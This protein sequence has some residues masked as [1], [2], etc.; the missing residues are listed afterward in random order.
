VQEKYRNLVKWR[1]GPLSSAR[2][3]RRASTGNSE[4]RGLLPFGSSAQFWNRMFSRLALLVAHLVLLVLASTSFTV[5]TAFANGRFQWQYFQYFWQHGWGLR[6]QFPYSLSVV[7]AYLAA[8]AVG[9]V[10]YYVAYRDGAKIIGLVG[11]LLC[12]AGVASFAFEA[13]HWLVNHYT[14]L[15]LSSPIVL[16]V[17]APVIAIQQYRHRAT[18]PT[19]HE[20]WG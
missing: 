9:V 3:R 18:E 13:T 1:D 15:I 19:S 20:L 16:G 2:Q 11:L 8:Y 7:L 5:V 6:Y 17:L 14:S 4:S 10:V 12:A